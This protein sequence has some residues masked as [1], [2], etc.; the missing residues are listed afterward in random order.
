MGSP[1]VPNPPV[2]YAL[3]RAPWIPVAVASRP[4]PPP[5]RGLVCLLLATAS[6]VALV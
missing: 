1:S 6:P 3:L 5:R 2:C 4:A